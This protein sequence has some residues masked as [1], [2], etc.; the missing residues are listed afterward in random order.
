LQ[1]SGKRFKAKGEREERFLNPKNV[2]GTFAR[3]LHE[4]TFTNLG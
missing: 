2:K 1:K 4:L 3:D